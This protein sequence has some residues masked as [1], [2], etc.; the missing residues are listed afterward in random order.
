MFEIESELP[1]PTPQLLFDA[2]HPKPVKILIGP[3]PG[4]E[5]LCE[6]VAA[7]EFG[8]VYQLVSDLAMA[9]YT[10]GG[11]GLSAPQIKVLKRVFVV[12]L[13]SPPKRVKIGKELRTV[14]HDRSELLVVVNPEIIWRSD[15]M[16]T[17]EESCLSYP[18]TSV[19]VSRHAKVRVRAQDHRGELWECEFDD[20]L[21]RAV[22]HEF[23]HI[24]GIVMTDRGKIVVDGDASVRNRL[25]ALKDR[26]RIPKSKKR[27]KKRG[28][29]R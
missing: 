17:I 10:V 13:F 27:S 12:D 8:A 2:P 22:Q 15:E 1:R 5:A 29:R 11:I 4:L 20:L 18:G 19:S 21:G 24:N 16:W 25:Q 6:P 9:M 26:P 14:P 7:D 23:D 28:R 3:H